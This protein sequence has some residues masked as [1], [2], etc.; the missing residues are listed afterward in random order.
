MNLICK[1]K[2]KVK[3]EQTLW[4]KGKKI[5]NNKKDKKLNCTFSGSSVFS[6]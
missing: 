5:I 2:T 1:D 6:W 4:S 3:K